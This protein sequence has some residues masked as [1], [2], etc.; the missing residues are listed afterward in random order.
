M[1]SSRAAPE[2]DPIIASDRSNDTCFAT[3][4]SPP[5][6]PVRSTSWSLPR[7]FLRMLVAA[8]Q[9]EQ[10]VIVS[11]RRTQPCL[12]A[13]FVGRRRPLPF[14]SLG[15][16]W[17]T[18][19]LVDGRQ[20]QSPREVRRRGDAAWLAVARRPHL[21]SLGRRLV[22]P[23]NVLRHVL[24]PVQPL[25]VVGKVLPVHAQEARA[26]SVAPVWQAR[27]HTF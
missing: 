24:D 19:L 16:S 2:E 23:Q 3:P 8:R 10:S 17:S 22:A 12:P 25:R 14:A 7:C 26:K 13:D 4:P 11:A 27:S 18:G 9:G 6:S 1:L 5:S 15:P 21:G 20:T